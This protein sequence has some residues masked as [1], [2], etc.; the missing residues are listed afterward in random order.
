MLS[1]TKALW[2]TTY[3]FLW[4][5][6]VH[7][8]RHTARAIEPYD[9]DRYFDFH[10]FG[11]HSDEEEDS[12]NWDEYLKQFQNSII[13][14]HSL[15]STVLRV[16]NNQR[17]APTF[18]NPSFLRYFKEDDLCYVTKVLERALAITGFPNMDEYY[19]S[20]NLPRRL[21]V[22]YDDPPFREDF[23]PCHEEIAYAYVNQYKVEGT[24]QEIDYIVFC[25]AYFENY[26]SFRS[27][28]PYM[29]RVVRNQVIDEGCEQMDKPMYSH[30][31]LV[32]HGE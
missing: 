9:R 22:Y 15:V 7:G 21:E 8:L 2:I 10:E 5:L 4:I 16:L 30:T 29:E 23:L 18:D 32:L 19:K 1:K 20:F 11:D 3:V 25:P 14:L 12:V 31:L 28:E 17:S 27:F 6:G 24:L 13:E 26:R